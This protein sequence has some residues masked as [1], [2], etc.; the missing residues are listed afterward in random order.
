MLKNYP[1]V[2]SAIPFPHYPVKKQEPPTIVVTV[3]HAPLSLSTGEVIF[4]ERLIF[5]FAFFLFFST[6]MIQ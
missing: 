1:A 4:G 5:L 6:L 3:R 2:V